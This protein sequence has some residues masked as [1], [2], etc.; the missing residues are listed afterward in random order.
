MSDSRTSPFALGEADFLDNVVGI[1]VVHAGV[2]RGTGPTEGGAH[3]VSA[4]K[5]D[6]SQRGGIDTAI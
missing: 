1:E 2:E 3:L 5:S 6:C 4:V